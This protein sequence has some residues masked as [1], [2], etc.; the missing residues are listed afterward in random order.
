[1]RLIVLIALVAG[2]GLASGAGALSLVTTA[3]TLSTTLDG[4]DQTVPG[5]TTA[6]QVNSETD[7]GGW[8]ITVSSTDFSDGGTETISVSNFDVRQLDVNIVRRAGSQN[9]PTSTQTTFATLS[10]T[11]LKIVTAAVGQAKGIY[12]ITPDF[13]MF[14]VGE[15][16]PASYDATVT[17]TISLGP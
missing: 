16:V 9:L 11:P 1:M 5:T 17:V 7:N 4:L 2:V 14:L 8:N 6:W 12:D 13:Q 10:G 3:I 15:T